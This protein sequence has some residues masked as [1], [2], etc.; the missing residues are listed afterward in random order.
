[1]KVIPDCEENKMKKTRLVALFMALMLVLSACS[2]NMQD[3][4]DENSTADEA[5]TTQVIS[6]EQPATEFIP[7]TEEDYLNALYGYYECEGF[8]YQIFQEKFEKKSTLDGTLEFSGAIGDV[9][10][11][12]NDDGAQYTITFYRA[13][14]WPMRMSCNSKGVLF[15]EFDKMMTPITKEQYDSVAPKSTQNSNNNQNPDSHQVQ[16]Y[17]KM[18]PILTLRSDLYHINNMLATGK[19]AEAESAIQEKIFD[20]LDKNVNDILK[21]R[22]YWV[23]LNYVLMYNAHLSEASNNIGVDYPFVRNYFLKEYDSETAIYNGSRKGFSDFTR[24][25]LNKIIDAKEADKNIMLYPDCLYSLNDYLIGLGKQPVEGLWNEYCDY[26]VSEVNTVYYTETF[27]MLCP[28]SKMIRTLPEDYYFLDW[29]GNYS[30]PASK[31]P[32]RV[33]DKRDT[34]WDE[35]E[36]IYYVNEAQRW[37]GYYDEHKV[38]VE[39]IASNRENHRYMLA[40]TI[41]V[42]DRNTGEFRES[43][44]SRIQVVTYIPSDG[45]SSPR[46]YDVESWNGIDENSIQNAQSRLNSYN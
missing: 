23:A 32:L 46:I 16:W 2:A 22:E 9:T 29:Y 20:R 35:V 44:N 1:M 33:E 14:Y 38:D 4:H 27:Y 13:T 39:C 30:L 21:T 41:Q 37:L 18:F 43:G 28:F 34:D 40:I 24:V 42:K 6:T 15:N 3:S 5:Q 7:V 36:Y 12:L 10:V 26:F 17:E 25:Y 19:K 31:M 11:K 45:S 8:Y